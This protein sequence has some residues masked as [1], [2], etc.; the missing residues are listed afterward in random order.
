MTVH[1]Q[2]DV[3]Q[4]Q[5]DMLSLSGRVEGMVRQS[6]Q[7]LRECDYESAVDFGRRD[8]E[9]DRIEVAIEE[10]C[11]KTLALHQPVAGDLRMITAVMKIS[12]ELENVADLAVNITERALGIAGQDGIVV[13]DEVNEMSTLAV[14]MLRDAIDAYVRSD[15]ELAMTVRTQDEQVDVLNQSVIGQISEQIRQRPDRV[16][17]LLHLFSASRLIEQIADHAT[18]I[19]EDVVYYVRGEIV[20]HTPMFQTPAS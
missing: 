11:L 1:L 7:M 14:R 3:N 8:D 5:E 20:R 2:R 17:G 10:S 15:A 6:V 9:I 16:D 19:A 12:G 4:L 18:V 13:P